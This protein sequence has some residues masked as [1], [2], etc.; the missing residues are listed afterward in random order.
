MDVYKINE[1]KDTRNEVPFRLNNLLDNISKEY[2]RKAG[3]RALL[4]EHRHKNVGDITVR[5][6]ADKLEQILDNLLTNAIKFTLSGTIRFHTEY[7]AGRLYVEVGDTGIGMDEE[8]FGTC[9]PSVRAC[10]AG[11]KLGR[12]RSWAFLSRKLL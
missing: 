1:T 12:F 5:G 8:T 7:M 10:G 3:G 4:F 9:L 11:D 2:A 6:D